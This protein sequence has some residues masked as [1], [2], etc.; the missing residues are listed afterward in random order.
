MYV[1]TSRV[2]VISEWAF[3]VIVSAYISF[4]GVCVLL[5]VV[6]FV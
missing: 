5:S 3:C 4:L 6:K 2:F 1:P